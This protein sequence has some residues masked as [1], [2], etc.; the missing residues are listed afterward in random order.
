MNDWRYK[1]YLRLFAIFAILYTISI[2]IWF[3]FLNEPTMY[4]HVVLAN[5]NVT[6]SY[7]KYYDNNLISVLVLAAF[8]CIML[9]LLIMHIH[10]IKMI[11]KSEVL[12]EHVVICDKEI[13]VYSNGIIVEGGGGSIRK[14]YVV[15]FR[16]AEGN[17]KS[18]VVDEDHYLSSLIGERVILSYKNYCDTYVFIGFAKID[19]DNCSD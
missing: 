5:G 16:F 1:Y 15:R 4:P 12:V 6:I 13:S 3:A 19:N 18:L 10:Q 11:R 14:D 2:G 8:V 9:S 17:E 7:E